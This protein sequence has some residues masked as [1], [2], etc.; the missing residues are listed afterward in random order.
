MELSISLSYIKHNANYTFAAVKHLKSFSMRKPISIDLIS[1]K[2]HE[3]SLLT[4]HGRY[5]VQLRFKHFYLVDC[6][7]GEELI[8]TSNSETFY[9]RLLAFIS[10]IEKELYKFWV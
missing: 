3:L 10:K 9:Y 1:R 5:V 8:K 4:S 7:T 6:I 2:L